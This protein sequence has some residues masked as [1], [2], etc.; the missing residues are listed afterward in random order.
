MKD[1]VTNEIHKMEKQV[2]QVK[3]QKSNKILQFGAWMPTLLD[4]INN[5]VRDGRF[6]KPPRGPIGERCIE[7]RSVISRLL[8]DG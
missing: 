7:T 3:L 1:E 5:A 4:R 2:K 6:T 8:V